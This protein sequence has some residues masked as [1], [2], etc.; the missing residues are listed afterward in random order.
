MSDSSGLR[1]NSRS[2]S[3]LLRPGRN[4]PLGSGRA[5]V[6]RVM[7]SSGSLPRC[8]LPTPGRNLP[9]RSGRALFEDLENEL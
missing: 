5:T 9:L 4:V 8:P 7:H 1:R 6:K 3:F 2:E